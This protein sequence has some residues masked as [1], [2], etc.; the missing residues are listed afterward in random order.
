MG[1]DEGDAT[2]T[3]SPA[4][5]DG[6]S[7]FES[8]EAE[9]LAHD[10]LVADESMASEADAEEANFLNPNP[11]ETQS[12]SALM[13]EA[14]P[15]TP[16]SRMD[17]ESGDELGKAEEALGSM[18]GK[19]GTL[20]ME[21]S[22]FVSPDMQDFSKP[23]KGKGRGKGK[24]SPG[25]GKKGSGKRGKKRAK[26]ASEEDAMDEDSLEEAKPKKGSKRAKAKATKPKPSK[27]S[28][29]KKTAKTTSKAKAKAK[30]LSKVKA[31]KAKSKAKAK[32]ASCASKAYRSP[33][34]DEAAYKAKQ[35]RKSAAYHRAFK[36]SKTQG[37]SIDESRELARAVAR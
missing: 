33:C 8:E 4:D 11:L 29:P 14:E 28:I 9:S 35:S 7:L 12:P 22:E 5:W 30:P 21:A 16:D 6:E 13:L 1:S 36:E 27:K 34:L 19:P 17:E 18:L 20:A 10:E 2:L 23:K 31:K 24:K 3:Y 32:T 15:A 26:A 37:K 25:K